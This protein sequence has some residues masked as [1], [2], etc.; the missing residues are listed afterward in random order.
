MIPDVSGNPRTACELWRHPLDDAELAAHWQAIED[1][2]GFHRL[3]HF[4]C[5]K[6]QRGSRLNVLGERLKAKAGEQSPCPPSL[7]RCD[8]GSWF[9]MVASSEVPIA[10]QVLSLAE[11]FANDCKKGEWGAIRPLLSIIPSEDGQ[12]LRPNQVVF[13]PVGVDVPNREPVASGLCDDLDAKRILRDV[14]KVKALDDALWESVLRES[15]P[16]QPG[17]SWEVPNSEKWRSF[18]AT[19]RISPEKVRQSFLMGNRYRIRVHRRDG[20][21]VLPPEVLRPGGLIGRDD[22]S[23]NQNVLVDDVVHAEDAASLTAAWRARLSRRHHGEATRPCIPYRAK[24]VDRKL[25]TPLQER[26]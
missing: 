3:V 25:P 17:H 10:V 26:A 13:A 9:A 2:V 6:R 4:S 15:L 24:R 18:W 11:A 19:L 23:Q 22:T 20:S 8:A 12:L 21:W 16:A 14:M 5:L 7:Q 1:A